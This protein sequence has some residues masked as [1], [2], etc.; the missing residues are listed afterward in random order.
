MAFLCSL[1]LYSQCEHDNSDDVS[2]HDSVAEMPSLMEYCTAQAVVDQVI[3]VDSLITKLLKVL[4]L[5]QMDNDN[6]IQQL[7]VDKLVTLR[8]KAKQ[9]KT[10]LIL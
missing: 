6:C 4:R 1:L 3:E 10:K 9:K 5:I 8:R 2:C 7:I